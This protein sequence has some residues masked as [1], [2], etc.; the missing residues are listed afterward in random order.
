MKLKVFIGVFVALLLFGL[1]GLYT[2]DSA[3]VGQAN[4][5]ESFFKDY[6]RQHGSYPTYETVER[7]FPGLYPNHDWYY[8]PNEART[9]ASFQYPMTLPIP[10][11]P[12]RSKI[13]EFI[14]IIYAYVVH[15][16]CEGL[17]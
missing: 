6:C 2:K 15:H 1:G 7:E 16:P 11:A 10:S 9:V 8:W 3:T 14:P 17:F 12:G 4:L 5:V 13:S